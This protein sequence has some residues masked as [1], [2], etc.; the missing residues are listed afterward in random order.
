MTRTA[1]LAAAAFLGC[2]SRESLPEPPAELDVPRFRTLGVIANFQP[3]WAYA[4]PYIVDL[5]IPKLGPE[6]SGRL[7]SIGSVART[8]AV[9]VAGSDWSV[10]S[11]DPLDA[12]EVGMTRRGPDQARGP[13]FIPEERVGL[14]TLLQAYTAAGAYAMQQE[15]E[16]GT[17]EVGK[18]ADLVVLDRD[19]RTIP[20]SEIHRV[21]VLLT[22][23]EGREVYRS[24]ELP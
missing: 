17:L 19:L 18:A 10:S 16:T 13:P 22:L 1:G 2:T 15:R 5:T 20:P 24:A 21:K 7:Y 14:D 3:L 6:R 11:L 8:G 23:L 4:D 9:V 12:I